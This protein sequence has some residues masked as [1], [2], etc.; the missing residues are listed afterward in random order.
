MAAIAQSLPFNL[1]MDVLIY[2]IVIVIW[3]GSWIATQVASSRRKAAKRA[4]ENPRP[5]RESRD[6][7]A[8]EL[9]RTTPREMPVE[10]PRP[11][12]LDHRSLSPDSPKPIAE[13]L[14]TQARVSS[15]SPTSLQDPVQPPEFGMLFR[16]PKKFAEQMQAYAEHQ[17]QQAKQAGTPSPV[18]Q[19][20]SSSPSQPSPTRPQA[21]PR[22]SNSPQARPRPVPQRS[23]R[24]PN[25]PPARPRPNPVR[26]QQARPPEPQPAPPPADTGLSPLSIGSARRD[27]KV[28]SA[29]TT[30]MSPIGPLDRDALRRAILLNE[31]IQ[32]PV[33]L[34]T[35]HLSGRSS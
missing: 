34:R 23:E 28:E 14:K 17:Q 30:R 5:K 15:P 10:Q 35:D 2:G 22:P 33:S 32:P 25:Q 8:D 4:R 7:F 31:I 20:Q 3:A 6:V 26:P 12:L 13:T 18:R 19:P 9:N 16:D 11:S 21:S 24:F 1:G 27:A 29:S